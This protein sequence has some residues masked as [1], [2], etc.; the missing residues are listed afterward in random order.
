MTCYPFVIL[1]RSRL[2]CRLGLGA[3]AIA[4][5]V[6]AGGARPQSNLA[7]TAPLRQ[8]EIAPQSSLPIQA[9]FDGDQKPDVAVGIAVG[10]GYV[11][12]I[13]FSTERPSASL[14]LAGGVPGMRIL[15]R[16]VNN[17]N[18]AD[19]IVTSCTS[20]IPIAVFL[21]DGKGH[22]Q[23][24]NPWNYIPVGLNSPYQYDSPAGHEGPASNTEERRFR[25]GALRGSLAELRLDVEPCLTLGIKEPAIE[26]V[27]SVPTP[28]G[29]P[30]SSNL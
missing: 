3:F 26:T 15:S 27:A 2:P 1:M 8:S 18:D 14:R 5:A 23:P 4:C 11:V 30:A 13:Q 17:D 24:D 29:P 9:D 25:I 16:D 21:G 28:R 6:L 20:L 12:Q 10:Q 22:F 19:L 7:I